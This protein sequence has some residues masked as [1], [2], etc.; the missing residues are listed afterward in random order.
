MK[1]GVVITVRENSNRIEKKCLTDIC[2]KPA[3]SILIDRLKNFDVVIATQEAGNERLVDIANNHGVKIFRG[4]D[5]SPLHRIVGAAKEFGFD[6]VVRITSDDILIDSFLLKK[7]IEFHVKHGLDYTYM[8]RCPVGV[9]GEVISANALNTIASELGDCEYISYYL[10]EKRFKYSEFYPPAEYQSRMRVGLDYPNDIKLLRVLHSV[11]GNNFGTLDIIHYSKKHPE[12][13][14][15]NDVPLVTFYTCNHNY[16]DYVKDCIDS[17]AKQNVDF[18]YLILDD[19]STD[20]SCDVIL[21]TISAYPDY[22]R[23]KID[24]IRN[25]KNLGLIDS[26]NY[27]MDKASGRY[28]MRIDSDDYLSTSTSSE[29]MIDRIRDDKSDGCLTAYYRDGIAETDRHY[30]SGCAIFKTRIANEYRYKNNVNFAKGL[31]F[32]Q[33]FGADERISFIDQPLW[34]YRKHSKS[35]TSKNSQGVF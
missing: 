25:N 8:G 31:E 29:I 22:L 20:N 6:H 30:H 24:V 4:F 33:K 2:G 9:A 13:F 7:Q 10:K 17:V 34:T 26:S 14:A 23:G 18:E 1:I 27:C 28:V 3:I 35:A 19:N 15:I 12:I 21:E 11:I 5:N 16:S 32:L